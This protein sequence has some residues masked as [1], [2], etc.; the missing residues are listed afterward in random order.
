MGTKSLLK[1]RHRERQKLKLEKEHYKSPPD[2]QPIPYTYDNTRGIGNW[3][4]TEDNHNNNQI[5][6]SS[7]P[8]YMGASANINDLAEETCLFLKIN[9]IY[10]GL[11]CSTYSVNIQTGGMSR[12]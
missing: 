8:G 11:Y 5:L 10:L 9:T 1:Q 4:C 7:P 2:A 12:D 3:L 6:L